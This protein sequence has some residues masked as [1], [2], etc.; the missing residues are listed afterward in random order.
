MPGRPSPLRVCH[1]IH[2]LRR[3][4]AEHLLL[5]LAELSPVAGLEMTVLSLMEEERR[6]F[7]DDLRAA[8]VTVGTLGLRT[9]WDPR[10]ARRTARLLRR[11]RPDVVH[12]HLKHADIVGAVAA[13]DL[14]IPMVSTLHVV[15]DEAGF[16]GRLKQRAAVR[17]RAGTAA[18]TIAVS[19][20]VRRW[21]LDTHR[22]DPKT[23]VTIRN[24]IVDRTGDPGDRAAV[25]DEWGVCEDRVLVV[26]VAIMR[27]GKGH[28]DVLEAAAMLPAGSP[29]VIALVG[30]GPEHERLFT[31]AR[32]LGVLGERV[33]FP[34][35]REDVGR[36]MAAAD[37]V[38]QPSRADA[39]PTSLI[40]ALA[41]GVPI[42]ATRVGGIPEIVGAEAGNL[43]EPGDV[44]GLAREISR[45]GDDPTTRRLMAKR[46]RERFEEEFDG[47]VWVG[48]LRDV[49]EE[50][51]GLGPDRWS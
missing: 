46:A 12:T 50:A 22:V 41:A 17:A 48:R 1:V 9:R 35:Y 19:D 5:D 16:V 32:D 45:L 42:V 8:G 23:V 18:R 25:R 43:V 7:A 29:V 27:P 13:R 6:S 24:G 2:D 26:M 47:W 51:L 30:L 34:G 10:A 28:A 49:Y 15:E 21:Y 4:G 3:G 20:A 33:I 37:V 31:K 39:L 44:G 40:R 38:V 14:G 36:I 11:W